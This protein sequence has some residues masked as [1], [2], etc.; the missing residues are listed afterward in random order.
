MALLQNTAE[1]GT[2]GTQV[3]AGNS[4]GASG[5]AFAISGI[6]SNNVTFSSAFAAHGS[7]SYYF[8]I[9]S[10]TAPFLQW[11]SAWTSNALSVR[12]YFR[13]TSTPSTASVIGQ[14][15]HASGTVAQIAHHSDG[16][17]RILD[18]ASG[19]IAPSG[20]AALPLDN[21]YR[22]ECTIEVATS[23]T[24]RLHVAYFAGESTTPIATHDASTYNFGTAQITGFRI[25]RPS[26]TATAHTYYI[27][28][29][30]ASDV[31]TFLGPFGANTPPTVSAGADQSVTAN[32]L[33]TLTGSASDAD[34]SIASQGWT[35][36]SGPTVTLGGSGATR[37]FTP[38]DGNVFVFQF[39]AT[40][41]DGASNNDT[42]TI[43]VRDSSPKPYKVVTNPGSWVNTG[44][45][46]DLVEAVDDAVT[47][48][49]AAT[50][51]APAGASIT[52]E[53][54]PNTEGVITVTT[55]DQA[56]ANSPDV[57]RV[58]EILVG[59]SVVYTSSPITL[60]TSIVTH[61][62]VTPSPVAADSVVTVRITDTE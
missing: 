40:D 52:Y 47:T 7:L 37:T 17:L 19:S 22:V 60:T 53:L 14:F 42:C 16:S 32:T 28:S 45:A 46:A 35:Q 18:T 62:H 8:N 38:T 4:G 54:T 44:G 59:G 6:A 20:F 13:P 57:T 12:F 56:S 30:A 9:A 5:D 29:L 27:D 36:I 1:G 26:S 15:R 48:T 43:R 50:P 34:G 10:A 2:N 39:E 55:H 41:D 31:T 23:T 3:S 33:V 51:A 11:G 49:Y 25:G 21:T 58:V 61:D 24:G